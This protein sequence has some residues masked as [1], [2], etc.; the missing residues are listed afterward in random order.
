MA[1]EGFGNST[2]IPDFLRFI[3]L[4]AALAG[5][6]YGGAY[7]LGTYPPEPTDVIRS[8]PHE[9]LRQG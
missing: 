6:V 2:V 1:N 5:A 4:L 8:L 3:I 7:A 9:K